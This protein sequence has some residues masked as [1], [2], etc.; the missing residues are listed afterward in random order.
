MQDE[1]AST[2]DEEMERHSRPP[3]SV[4]LSFPGICSRC[5]GWPVG[6]VV[7]QPIHASLRW[8]CERLPPTNEYAV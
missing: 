2:S 5:I 7:G 3:V 8:C 4:S 1:A 6:Q